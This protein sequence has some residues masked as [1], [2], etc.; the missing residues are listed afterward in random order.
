MT[1]SPFL[2]FCTTFTFD[3]IVAMTNS[4][5]IITK[6]SDLKEKNKFSSEQWRNRGLV[7]SET[8]ICVH[9]NTVFDDLLDQLIIA[10]QDNKST[11]FTR[12]VFSRTLKRLNI[13]DFDTEERAFIGDMFIMISRI[14]S[15]DISR[16]L[17]RWAYG[18]AL[19]SLINLKLAL[20]R[21]NPPVETLS[22]P[23]VKCGNM[24]ESHI[25]EKEESSPG[26]S[27]EVVRCDT[28][29]EYN[30]LDHGPGIKQLEFGNYQWVERLDKKEY[31]KEQAENRVE[32]IRFFRKR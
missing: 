27:Y 16:S 20:N 26:Y 6:L 9:L 8:E 14:L 3:Y 32:Q 7:P 30:L 13:A 28:C 1:V 31:T 19:G 24:L 10:V 2:D 29:D 15:M 4:E 17:N 22:Q 23:C 12:S 5:S 25:L 18:P 21:K 11:R